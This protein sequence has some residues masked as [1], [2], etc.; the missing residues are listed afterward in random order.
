[1]ISR[2][3]TKLIDKCGLGTILAK[4]ET[5]L[6]RFGKEG[7]FLPIRETCGVGFCV[8]PHQPRLFFL[9]IEQQPSNPTVRP[10]FFILHCS[11]PHPTTGDPPTIMNRTTGVVFLSLVRYRRRRGALHQNRRCW[12]GIRRSSLLPPPSRAFARPGHRVTLFPSCSLLPKKTDRHRR[13]TTT[14]SG[15]PPETT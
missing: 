3:I 10:P 11:Q 6:L 1:M 5:L 12:K 8:Q 7:Q 14:S 13:A 2:L 4:F 9:P 15:S